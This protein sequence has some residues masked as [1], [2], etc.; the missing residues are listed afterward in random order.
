MHI[1]SIS[2]EK[3]SWN[4]PVAAG[5]VLIRSLLTAHWYMTQK[6]NEVNFFFKNLWQLGTFFPFLY[7]YI[8]ESSVC[9]TAIICLQSGQVVFHTKLEVGSP[10]NS[11]NILRK[12]EFSPYLCHLV[13]SMTWGMHRVGAN[14]ACLNVNYFL[15]IFYRFSREFPAVKGLTNGEIMQ[16]STFI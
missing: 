13:M 3:D 7:I 11:F 9:N 16:C 5:L 4:S 6:V 8:T 15:Y 10:K 1:L 12:L 2:V 14:L